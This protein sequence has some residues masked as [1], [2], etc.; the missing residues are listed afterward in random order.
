[1]AS[2]KDPYDLSSRTGAIEAK[3]ANLEDES[4]RARDKLH[5]LSGEVS[6]FSHF[7]ASITDFQKRISSLEKTR[8]WSLGFSAGVGAVA[9]AAFELL[10]SIFTTPK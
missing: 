10:K 8:S 7:P 9:A 6:H 1:M 4:D 5:K 2:P 3:V